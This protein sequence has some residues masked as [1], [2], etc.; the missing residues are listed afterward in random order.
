[1]KEWSKLMSSSRHSFQFLFFIVPLFVFFQSQCIPI[2]NQLRKDGNF[3]VDL[4][5]GNWGK[6]IKEINEKK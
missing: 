5:M 2:M 1:M 4:E 3:E 6:L